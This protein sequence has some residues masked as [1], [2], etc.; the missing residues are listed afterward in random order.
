MSDAPALAVG[1]VAHSILNGHLVNSGSVHL[2]FE[3][4]FRQEP[5]VE[6]SSMLALLELAKEDFRSS[7]ASSKNTTL[8]EVMLGSSV[9][10][11]KAN[12]QDGRM[13]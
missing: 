6:E 13:P 7:G 2:P 4:R 5:Q 8:L 3:H 9:E 11:V 1:N 10:Q 12:G